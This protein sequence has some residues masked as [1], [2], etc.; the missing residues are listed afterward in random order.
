M[1]DTERI[2]FLER[3]GANVVAGTGETLI[4]ESFGVCVNKVTGWVTRPTL[5]EA[6]DD[7]EREVR[8]THPE[9]IQR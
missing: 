3:T 9:L 7:A 5:R 4:P 6:I 2:D 8:T 1:T